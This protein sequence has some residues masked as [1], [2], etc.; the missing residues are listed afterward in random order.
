MIGGILSTSI[1]AI[2]VGV[3]AVLFVDAENRQVVRGCDCS[4]NGPCNCGGGFDASN[5]DDRKT[6]ATVVMVVGGVLTAAGIPM[7]IV[8]ARKVPIDPA[9]EPKASLAPELRVS[10]SKAALRWRF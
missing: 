7:I 10:A 6:T 8:G 1:G 2:L 9:E 4:T 5:E 3:G